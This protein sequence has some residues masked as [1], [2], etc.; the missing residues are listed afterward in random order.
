MRLAESITRCTGTRCEIREVCLRHTAETTRA[1]CMDFSM[2]G[3]TVTQC[4]EC[5]NF[6]SNV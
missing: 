1:W 2:L 5:Q 4:H 6:I 3:Q